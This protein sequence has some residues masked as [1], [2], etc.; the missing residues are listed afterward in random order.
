MM[1][2]EIEVTWPY[3]HIHFRDGE[4]LFSSPAGRQQLAASA[5]CRRLVVV[6]LHRAYVFENLESVQAELSASV[7][8]LAPSDVDQQVPFLSVGG[9]E[10]GAR[11]EKCRGKSQ[12]SG[13][14][15]VEDVDVDGQIFRRLVFLSNTAL[16]QS[17][18][19]ISTGG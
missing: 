16:V 1:K 4:W 7:M 18:A 12:F 11:S 5:D 3:Q 9:G 14:F 10:L 2:P 8:E 15:V 17:E 19:K 6:H 13:E